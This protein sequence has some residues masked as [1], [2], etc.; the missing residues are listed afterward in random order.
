MTGDSHGVSGDA[1]DRAFARAAVVVVAA[2]IV[3]A[4][5]AA[6]ALDRTGQRVA[7]ASLAAISAN[8][9]T[10]AL[11]R[12]ADMLDE[13]ARTSPGP[14]QSIVR[15]KLGW[16]LDRLIGRQARRESLSDLD[17][18][19]FAG[20][21]EAL[22]EAREAMQADFQ[23]HDAKA[24]GA[25]FASRLVPLAKRMA[26]RLENRRDRMQEW[27]RIALAG[28]LCLHLLG[29]GGLALGVLMP[30]RTRIARW[31]RASREAA[32]EHR[33]RL[34][35]DPNTQLPNAA[36]LNA[37]LEALIATAAHAPFQTAVMRIDLDK[38]RA[39]RETLGRRAADDVLRTTAR[40]IRAAVRSTDFAAHLGGDDF[41]LVAGGLA[42][43]GD[44]AVIAE[45]VQQALGKPFTLQ[46][47]ARR[48]SCCI[49]VTLLSDDL[50]CPERV[51]GNAEIALLEA[52]AAGPG[53][54]SYFRDDLRVAAEK[55]AAL[56]TDLATGLEQ[57]EFVPFFQ[58]QID[59]ATGAMSGFEALVR[60][61]HPT[62]GLL[63]PGAFLDIAERAELIDRIG[64]AMLSQ[65]LAALT[66]WDAAGLHV[67]K[68]GINFAVGQ[69][70][71]PRLI[72]KIKWE[73]ERNDV[74]PSR[75]SVEVLETVLI[76][77]DADLVVRN[78]RGL[79]SAGFRIELDD[80][81]TGHASIQNLRRFM[82]GHIKIDR[83]FVLGI[84]TS[85]EQQKLTAS[86]IA[87]ARALGVRTLAEGIETAEALATL[88]GLGCDDGQGYH[89]GRPMSQADTFGW[90]RA[91]A[92]RRQ[93]SELDSEGGAQAAADGP[94]MP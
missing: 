22:R 70:C 39:L 85:E 27:S 41:M 35:H 81:G 13:I 3:L 15:L 89:V 83:S 56:F 78:L 80:F 66:A 40:R 28:A 75:L 74:E 60:W 53:N 54:V 68:V 63:A 61:R 33:F 25:L 91:F 42:D 21:S 32:E 44:A 11:H 62:Q 17:E 14:E 45:R 87:M 34:L 51:G 10:A 67:P 92:A 59:L 5:G 16:E 18:P 26:L 58:P 8:A 38:F 9:E 36:A 29:A 69:L 7:R 31:V 84:E 64:E 23:P 94:N 88:R 2:W 71:D 82:A 72:E 77:T 1:P 48:V 79:A 93:A 6:F 20:L 86:M 19:G 65:T 76:K 55:R 73:V 46:G 57:G 24:L 43:G 12:A 4:F 47:G 49:G 90:L 37:H 50:A 52:Q 30:A